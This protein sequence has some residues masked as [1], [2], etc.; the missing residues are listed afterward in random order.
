MAHEHQPYPKTLYK[1]GESPKTVK[2]AQQ[3]AAECPKA[4]GWRESPKEAKEYADRGQTD[5][6]A[7]AKPRTTQVPVGGPSAPKNEDT[8]PPAV[9]SAEKK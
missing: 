9:A 5:A 7:A 8:K 3:E 1:A 4:E 6:A 2:N